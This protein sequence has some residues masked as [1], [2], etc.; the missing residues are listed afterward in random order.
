MVVTTLVVLSIGLSRLMLGVHYVSDVVAGWVLGLA[1]LSGATAA[2]SIWR[3]E[4]G[5]APVRAAEGVEPEAAPA[6]RGEQE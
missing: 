6:L 3:T 5:K 1:W 2:F 4:E